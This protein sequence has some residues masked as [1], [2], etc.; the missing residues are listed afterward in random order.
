MDDAYQRARELNRLGEYK[1]R[2]R[3]V[4]EGENA[5][6]A[7]IECLE[8][9]IAIIDE[10]SQRLDRAALRD[11]RKSAAAGDGIWDGAARDEYT[12]R[13]GGAAHTGAP[14]VA[15]LRRVRACGGAG[16]PVRAALW[17]FGRVAPRWL[18]RRQL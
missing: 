15:W 4:E 17:H 12:C 16:R 2:Y 9:A 8:E 7:A 3:I 11:A 14:L 18:S 13:D 10:H 6:D 1:R 5:R